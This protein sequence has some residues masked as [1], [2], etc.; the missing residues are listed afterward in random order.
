[1]EGDG[2][3]YS[4]GQEIAL[5]LIPKFT[6]TISISCSLGLMYEVTSDYKLG[7]GT[8]SIQRILFGMSAVDILSNFAWFLSSWALP[9]TSGW[10][11]ASGNA[12]SCNFQGFFLQLAIGAPLYNCSLALF[13]VMIIKYRW[14][15]ERLLWLEGWVHTFILIFSIG[16][17]ILMLFLGQYNQ[18]GVVR[19]NWWLLSIVAFFGLLLMQNLLVFGVSGLLDHRRPSRLWQQ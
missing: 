1:M 19:C 3:G 5:A 16:S 2:S 15:A 17:S 13:Y 8:N 10:P 18:S 12:A 11:F 7:H 9:K 6:S 14:S 4:V